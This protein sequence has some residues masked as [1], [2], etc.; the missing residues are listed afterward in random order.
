MNQMFFQS[1]NF[2]KIRSLLLAVVLFS[3]LFLSS[4]SSG[5]DASLLPAFGAGREELESILQESE[6]QREPKPPKGITICVDPGHGFDD[7]GT[8]SELLGDV[9]EKDI[10][11][12]VSL[13]LRDYLEELGFDVIMTHDGTKIPMNSADDGNNK[14]KPQERTAYANALGNTI[15]YYISIHC[16]AF[17]TSDVYGSI[18]FYV[19]DATKGTVGDKEIA[20]CINEQIIADFPDSKSHTSVGSYHVIRYTKVP[21][22]LI[23]IGY[24]TNEGDAQNMLNEEWQDKYAMSLADALDRYYSGEYVPAE[25]TEASAT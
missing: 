6:P 20:A 19:D 14:F 15:D 10:T 12:S 16:N 7:G 8:S 17:D 24:V 2:L 23:E 22:S 25:D 18:V 1:D 13:K 9:L 4:C 3:C 11:L 5:L 21:A